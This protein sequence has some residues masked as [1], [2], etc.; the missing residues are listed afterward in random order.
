MKVRLARHRKTIPRNALMRKVKI[1][2]QT[3]RGKIDCFY[4][5]D[6]LELWWI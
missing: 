4:R 6:W 1:L 2:H 5:D 3:T